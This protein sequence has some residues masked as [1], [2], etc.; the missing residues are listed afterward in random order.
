[1]PER[2]HEPKHVF[3]RRGI[4]GAKDFNRIVLERQQ[5]LKLVFGQI[6]Q[7]T[8]TGVCCS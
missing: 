2:H 1:M 8:N 4:R 7:S 5:E 6:G 3:G